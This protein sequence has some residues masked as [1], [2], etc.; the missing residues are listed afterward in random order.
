MQDQYPFFVI[1]RLK[2]L[3]RHKMVLADENAIYLSL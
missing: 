2:Y 1:D 3:I